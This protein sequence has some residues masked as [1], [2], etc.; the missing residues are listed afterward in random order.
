[1]PRAGS[2]IKIG[3]AFAK[4]IKPGAVAESH[5]LRLK[6]YDSSGKIVRRL[7][8]EAQSEARSL[9]AIGKGGEPIS[10]RVTKT[11]ST[12]VPTDVPYSRYS[13][14]AEHKYIGQ[15]LTGEYI[16]P[17]PAYFKKGTGEVVDNPQTKTVMRDEYKNR[18]IAFRRKREATKVK[19]SG[20]IVPYSYT[21][22]KPDKNITT[23]G[24]YENIAI[25]R[26]IG[27][28]SAI[29]SKT[30]HKPDPVRVKPDVKISRTQAA[31]YAL[32]QMDK[33]EMAPQTQRA[34]SPGVLNQPEAMQMPGQF[35][36]QQEK[37]M[38][39]LMETR[40]KGTKDQIT[41]PHDMPYEEAL[42]MSVRQAG[43]PE[44]ERTM[45]P[46]TGTIPPVKRL[47]R[48]EGGAPQ[49][50]SM[51]WKP[52]SEQSQ[53]ATRAVE[54][55]STQ[56]SQVRTR[57]MARGVKPSAIQDL[58]TNAIMAT[59]M[60]KAM[61]GMRSMEGKMWK[62]NINTV[63]RGGASHKTQTN[64]DAMDAF[65]KVAIEWID[66]SEAASKKYPNAL[67]QSI[68]KAFETYQGATQGGM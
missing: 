28:R 30:T 66:N 51:R 16:G 22:R 45:T 23:K 5:L 35:E 57:Q 3:S 11:T 67:I 9:A 61:G 15:E 18:E 59:Q 56:A 68:Q 7:G 25:R 31:M 47:L 37:I 27:G 13:K 38:G 58:E 29:F 55:A 39:R 17:K 33:G 12:K 65:V 60:W 36:P 64:A 62:R 32:R 6:W 34:S 54:S 43:M 53:S 42:A 52:L 21:D 48:M 1:M 24:M 14:P 26:S 20:E 44:A 49:F 2:L 10:M 63:F 19:E 46:A 50:E 4:R 40:D 41:I 8:K